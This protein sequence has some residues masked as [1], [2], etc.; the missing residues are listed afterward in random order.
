VRTHDNL[1][2]GEPSENPGQLP[3]LLSKSESLPPAADQ[4]DNI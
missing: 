2:R 3:E 4:Q 1:D